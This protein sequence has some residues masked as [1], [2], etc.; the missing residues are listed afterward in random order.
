MLRM[1][2]ILILISILILVLVLILKL[3]IMIIISSWT[4]RRWTMSTMDATRASASAPR[5]LRLNCWKRTQ[6]P[7][8]ASPQRSS[9]RSTL[10]RRRKPFRFPGDDETLLGVWING[11]ES[12][13]ILA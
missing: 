5:R 10:T 4:S 11:F 3:I 9:K 7:S 2:L 12:V 13:S 1:V 6:A 8:L